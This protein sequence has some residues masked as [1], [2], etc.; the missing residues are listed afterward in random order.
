MVWPDQFTWVVEA[1][2]SEVQGGNGGVEQY[3]VSNGLG[4]LI[5]PHLAP[6]HFQHLNL[7]PSAHALKSDE[8]A[9]GEGL[10]LTMQI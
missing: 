2:A 7:H 5:L 6:P 4:P 3:E 9:N 8:Q 1:V 10:L